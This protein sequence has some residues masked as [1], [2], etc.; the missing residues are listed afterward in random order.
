MSF[1]LDQLHQVLYHDIA[2]QL[3]PF[4]FVQRTVTLSLDEFVGSFS[5]FRGGMEGHDWFRRGMMRQKLGD[6]RGGLCFEQHRQFPPPNGKG[7]HA[8]EHGLIRSWCI[9]KSISKKWSGCKRHG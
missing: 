2:L 3:V 4:L 1:K 5:H 8:R 7:C 9:I 6:F